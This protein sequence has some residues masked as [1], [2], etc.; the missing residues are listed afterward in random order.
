[1]VRFIRP[2][3]LVIAL[4]LMIAGCQDD[5]APILADNSPSPADLSTALRVSANGGDLISATFHVYVEETPGEP[6][7]IHRVTADW[8]ELTVTWNSFG[9]AFAPDIYGSFTPVDPGWYSVDVTAL[10]AEWMN[11]TH[12][13]FGLLLDQVEKNY[14]RTKYTSRE[15]TANHPYLEVC[16]GDDGGRTCESV[17]AAGDAYIHE[18]NPDWSAGPTD[19]LNT[20]WLWSGDL[21]KQ[22]MLRFELPTSPPLDEGCTSTIGYWKNHAGF[23]PQEDVVSQFLPI[24]L[25]NEDGDKSLAVTSARI[26]VN[27]L[28][29]RTYGHPRNGITKLYAQLLAAKLNIANGASDDDIAEVIEAA[30]NFLADHD[31]TDW[32]GLNRRVKM[33]VLRA[34]NMLDAYNNGRIGP[35]HCDAPCG[36]NDDDD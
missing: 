6:V 15:A 1:M 4:G 16:F 3:I 7:N 30:D 29:M 20:G 23:G 10:V 27:V 11:E 13:N 22:A 18:A 2:L 19:Y 25:G 8:D 28:K 31:Y 17:I 9:G 26:A 21:E 32:R 36:H 34:K 5:S 14:P 12:D 33:K 35:G 24:W